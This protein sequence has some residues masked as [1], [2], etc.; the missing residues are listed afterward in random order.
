MLQLS[1]QVD[2]GVEAFVV[3]QQQLEDVLR[4]VHPLELG[5]VVLSV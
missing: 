3:S 1:Q 2:N 4:Q 5:D